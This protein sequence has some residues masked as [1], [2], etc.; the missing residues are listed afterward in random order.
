V[1]RVEP[2]YRDDAVTLYHGDCQEV[3]PTLARGSV[4]LLLTDPPYG[5][6]YTGGRSQHGPI[7][8]DDG[9]LDVAAA[10]RLALRALRL[11][12]HFY[13]FG[14][15]DIA[16]LTT[17]TTVGLIWD[18]CKHGSGDLAIP[19]GVAHEP[20]LF[21][22]WTPYPSQRGGGAVAARLRRG[23]VLRCPTVN[24]GRGALLHP[25][26]KPIPLLRD[27]IE[28]SSLIGETVLDPFAGAGSTL[29]AARM[30]GRRAVGVEVE[31]KYCEVIA[32]RLAQGAFDFGVA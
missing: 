29:L 23:S 10:L 16:P 4:D 11:N 14:P 32:T 19:W 12:R 18:R 20:V 1:V 5:I 2:Y 22:V 25:T 8:G 21:G 27:L 3:L 26:E 6:G 31:E 30:E 7:A 17:G 24:N 15:L 9:S 28:A 13:V